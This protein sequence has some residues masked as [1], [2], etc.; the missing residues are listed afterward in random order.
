[1]FEVAAVRRGEETFHTG[2]DGGINE[3]AL[4]LTARGAEN[5]DYGVDA[6][7]S[8]SQRGQG[9]LDCASGCIRREFGGAVGADKDSDIERGGEEGGQN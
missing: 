9:V 1:M 4:L 3:E 8:G 7:E 6:L 2:G 5:R